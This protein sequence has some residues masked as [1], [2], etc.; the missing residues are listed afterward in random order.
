MGFLFREGPLISAQVGHDCVEVPC[1][2]E[3]WFPKGGLMYW[4]ASGAHQ[5]ILVHT[6]R[7][8]EN[9]RKVWSGA[10][11]EKPPGAAVTS[12]GTAAA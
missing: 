6:V 3:K 8:P 1:A 7:I 12:A 5:D 11:R 4:T 9:E 10:L 2:L